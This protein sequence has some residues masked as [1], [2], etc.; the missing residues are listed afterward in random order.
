MNK[1]PKV[2]E[3]VTESLK[4]VQEEISNRKGGETVVVS[5]QMRSLHS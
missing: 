3:A 5:F 2:L 1:E 4:G